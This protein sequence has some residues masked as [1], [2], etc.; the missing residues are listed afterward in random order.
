MTFPLLP[1]AWLTA[2]K[3]IV[4]YYEVLKHEIIYCPR[5]SLHNINLHCVMAK[6]HED[7]LQAILI[8]SAF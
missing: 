4:I 7:F 2:W 6:N 5:T 1:Q 8:N 3:Q